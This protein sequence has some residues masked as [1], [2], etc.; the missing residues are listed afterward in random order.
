MAMMGW[1]FETR[2]SLIAKQPRE[3]EAPYIINGRGAAVEVSGDQG[4]GSA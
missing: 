2:A 4:G 1:I 3:D